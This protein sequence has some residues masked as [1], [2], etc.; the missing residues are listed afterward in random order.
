MIHVVLP[1]IELDTVNADV[2]CQEFAIPSTYVCV[3]SLPR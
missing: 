1:L 2:K 3:T